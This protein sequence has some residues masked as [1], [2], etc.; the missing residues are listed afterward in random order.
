M[1]SA[2]RST[3][4]FASLGQLFFDSLELVQCCLDRQ[5]SLHFLNYFEKIFLSLRF[6]VE[7]NWL[8]KRGAAAIR[9]ASFVY[10][11]CSLIIMVIMVILMFARLIVQFCSHKGTRF[12]P[13][14]SSFFPDS[15]VPQL[16]VLFQHSREPLTLITVQDECVLAVFLS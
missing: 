12:N 5:Q 9:E 14:E 6:T 13:T 4:T 3:L 15:F 10:V 7:Q 1:D 16:G 8:E 2:T 11:V